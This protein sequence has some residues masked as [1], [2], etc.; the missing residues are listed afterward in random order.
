M[1]YQFRS[2]VR[3]A[4]KAAMGEMFNLAKQ[5]LQDGDK[6][7]NFASGHPSTEV[8]QDEMIKKYMN[9]AMEEAD[10]ELFQYGAHAGYMPL[11]R[12][13]GRFVNE[14]GSIVKHDDDLIITYGSTEAVFLTASAFVNQGDKVIVEVP[15]Y[16]NA[17]KAFQLLGGDLIGVH[18]ESDGV[19]LEELEN[20]MKQGAKL[21]YT[22]PNFGNPSG[23]TMNY[24]KRKAVYELGIKYGVPIMEDDI[25]GSLRYR[26]S[27]LPCIK[28]FDTEGVVIY[29]SSISKVIAPAMRIGYMVARL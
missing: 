15:S 17:I 29:V 22:I 2:E 28:E 18:I 12:T 6:L 24:Q 19:N 25:Y 23:I 10:K 5:Y 7:I 13:L 9:L 3:N 16:V 27:R 20:A 21:F 14:K 4:K 8:F 26:N 1:N 11:R